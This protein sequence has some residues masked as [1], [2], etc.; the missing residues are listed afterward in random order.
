MARGEQ[1]TLSVPEAD[2][3][4]FVYAD[5]EPLGWFLA[6]EDARLTFTISQG[7]KPGAARLAL[8]ASTGDY[9]GWDKLVVRG[10]R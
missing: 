1:V 2:A 6:D 7:A 8:F 4:H 3:W 10:G 9:L 5:T